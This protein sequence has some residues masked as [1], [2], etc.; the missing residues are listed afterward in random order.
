MGNNN[1][2]TPEVTEVTG[3]K[4]YMPE[5]YTEASEPFFRGKGDHNVLELEQ[6]CEE[7][8]EYAHQA[9]I[10]FYSCSRKADS[11][12]REL[13]ELRDK[14]EFYRNDTAKLRDFVFDSKTIGHPTQSIFEAVMDKFISLHEE[15][16]NLQSVMVAAAEEIKEHWPAHCDEDGYGPANLMHRLEK[17]IAANYPG[18]KPGAFNE[19]REENERLKEGLKAMLNEFTPNH[20]GELKK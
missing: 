1:K 16:E 11:L 18:Y 3:K 8:K 15:I 4:A 9:D 17:G 2:H 7:Y 14:V 10:A 19:L 6:I 13:S 20:T 5:H 12:T